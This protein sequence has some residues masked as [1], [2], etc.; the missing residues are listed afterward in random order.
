ML[1][2]EH[3]KNAKGEP[4]QF[5]DRAEKT[6]IHN[7]NIANALGYEIDITSLTAIVRRIVEQKFFEV[8]PAMYMPV[9]VGEGAWAASLTTYRDFSLGG[10]FE[11][12][13]VN[14]GSGQS[15]FAEMDGNV[16][17]ITVPIINWA[18]QI[19]W[20]I[21]DLELATRSG[22]WDLVTSKERSR[23]KNW[24]LGIQ[25]VS[26][27]GLQGVNAVRGLLTQSDVTANTT[28]ITKFLKDMTSTEFEAFLADIME[29]Y[30]ANAER[31]AMPSH[32]IIPEGDYTG[33]GVA[34]DETFP[35]KSKLQRLLEVFKLITMNDNFNILP[36]SYADK[37][38]NADFVN[39]NK[40]RYTLLNYDEDSVR[41]DIPV[42]Y[43]NTL[44]N[45]L[46]GAQY[47]NVG[48]GQFTGCKAYRPKEMI[49]YDF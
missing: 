49:Y 46:N 14:T 44:Q 5:N 13:I 33:L 43:S 23:K 48:Y 35:L 34:T 25:E 38:V 17:S 24:D 21:F 16:D 37:T 32:F 30:R 9:R 39:L 20:S 45:T 22:N 19:A 7:Q 15:R 41:I 11:E 29:T 10:A 47:S 36:L 31:T 6:I 28:L 40:N 8:P 18:K 27:I 26:F 4:I 42:D 1:I 2:V 12:G 3:I